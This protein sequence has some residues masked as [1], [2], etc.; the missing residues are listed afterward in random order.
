MCY[1]SWADA[2]SRLQLSGF[3]K[4]TCSLCSCDLWL[5]PI[6]S[7]V[8]PDCHAILRIPISVRLWQQSNRYYSNCDALRALFGEFLLVFDANSIQGSF[9]GKL[10]ALRRLLLG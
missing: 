6:I 1:V 4:S 3:F 7:F 9:L 10:P 5:G 2:A 8:E